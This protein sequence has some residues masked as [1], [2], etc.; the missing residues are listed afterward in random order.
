MI[1]CPNCQHKEDPG[2]VFCSNCGTQLV[3]P[4]SGKTHEIH[5]SETKIKAIQHAPFLPTPKVPLSSWVSLHLIESGQ[6]ISLADRNEFTLGRA[7][8]GQPIMPDVDLT[9][10][11]AH[12]NGVSR[13]HCVIKKVNSKTFIM[14]LGSSNGTYHIGVRLSPYAETPINHGDVITLGKLKI[15]VLIDQ[16]QGKL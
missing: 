4:N 2:A 16:D 9:A 6:I 10:F 12:A 15:Q 7:S 11:N 14:D 1:F 5:T 13:L 3:V 8:E